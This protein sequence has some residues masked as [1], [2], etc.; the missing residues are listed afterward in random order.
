M[1]PKKALKFRK[2]KSKM[3]TWTRWGQLGQVKSLRLDLTQA[4]TKSESRF[5]NPALDITL[6]KM[7]T[8][9]LVNETWGSERSLS[10]SFT[11]NK[12]ADNFN[13][14]LQSP[15][16]MDGILSDQYCASIVDI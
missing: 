14:V 7:S 9:W 13:M 8:S 5:L 16:M 2:K 6:E 1:N 11:P 12:M 10:W 15:L 3:L 4:E